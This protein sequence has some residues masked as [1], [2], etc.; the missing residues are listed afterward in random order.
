MANR[1]TRRKA[2]RDKKGEEIRPDKTFLL[3]IGACALVFVV[4][5]YLTPAPVLQQVTAGG[6]N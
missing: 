4:W 2:Q 6:V 1:S 3:I 5:A